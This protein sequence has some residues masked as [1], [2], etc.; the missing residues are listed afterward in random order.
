MTETRWLSDDE[1]RTWRA[2]L[3]STRLLMNA[4]DRQLTRD[5]GMSLTDY[6][7]L[8]ALSEAP[9][10]RL[11]MRALADAVVTT[12]SGVTRA[13]SRLVDAGW[14]RRVECDE[15]KRGMLAE[16]T[17]AGAAKLAQASPGHVEAVR[18]YVFDLLGPR[19]V[20]RFG[21][22]YTAMRTHLLENT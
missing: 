21:D 20:T 11:R 8:V 18:S 4:L 6:E 12:R 5:S 13:I 3:D 10:R 1:Q 16:L 9:G 22:T 2:Y 17:D 14:V 7:L 15:D 19:D